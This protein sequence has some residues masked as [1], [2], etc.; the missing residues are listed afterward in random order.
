MASVTTPVVAVAVVAT[1]AVV[2]VADVPHRATAKVSSPGARK[3]RVRTVNEAA[4]L[5]HAW[6]RRSVEKNLVAGDENAA[7]RLMPAP[8][9]KVAHTRLTLDGRC[10]RPGLLPVGKLVTMPKSS[11]TFSKTCFNLFC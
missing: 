9:L 3:A 5:R 6:D 2:V 4:V 10:D 7:S 1:A 11:V 8:T